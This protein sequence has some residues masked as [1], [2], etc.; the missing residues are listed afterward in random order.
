MSEEV[1]NEVVEG[2][3]KESIFQK[4]K[5][6]FI[7]HKK[8]R[9]ILLVVIVLLLCLLLLGI[10]K[11]FFHDKRKGEN[12]FSIVN[13]DKKSSGK[14]LQLEDVLV[15]KTKNGSLE[16][17]KKHLY[18]EPA[19]RYEIKE[20][21]K[22][23]YE[24]KIQ[25]VPSDKIINAKF[26]DQNVID[27]QWAFQSTK[28]FVVNSI[29]PVDGS[30]GISPNTTIEILFSYP[31]LTDIKDYVEISPAVEGEFVSNGRLWIFKPSAPLQTNTVYTVTVKDSLK[32]GEESLKEP[33]Q[34]SFSTFENSTK[35]TGTK[36]Y[37]SI[38]IDDI[39]TFRPSDPIAIRV[40]NNSQVN[41]KVARV[42]ILKVQS[43][44]DFQKLLEK[45]TDVQTTSLGNYSFQE[46]SKDLYILNDSLPVGYYLGNVY[47]E[48]G[49]ILFSFPIQVH[50]LSAYLVASQ[51][52]ILV[53]V[54]KGDSLLEGIPVQYLDKNVKTDK[55]G[56]AKIASYNTK[57]EKMQIVKIGDNQ[58]IFV[59]V[60]TNNNTQYPNAYIYTDRPL[61]KNTDEIQI[62]GYI[63]MAHFKEFS[64]TPKD[65]YLSVGDEA[66]PVEIKKDGTFMT[67][68]SLKNYKD[69]YLNI[70]LHYQNT[71]IGNRGVE[72]Y[73]YEKEMYDF[74]IDMD[75]NY[76]KANDKF[77]FTVRVDHISGVKVPN[78]EITATVGKKVYTAVTDE[79]GVASFDIDTEF[80]NS[81]ST[82]YHSEYVRVTSSL[83]EYAAKGIGFY[84]YV[85]DRYITLDNY[86]YQAKKQS[87]SGEIYYLSNQTDKG[88][89]KYINADL[90]DKMYQ[91]TVSVTLEENVSTRHLVGQ[92]YNAFTKQNEPYYNW[93]NE[94][95]NVYDTSVEVKN[96]QFQMDIPY[97]LK[98]STADL[99]YS[100]TLLITMK[101]LNDVT[102]QYTG[103]IYRNS[104]NVSN[105]GYYSYESYPVSSNYNYFSYYF[106]YERKKNSI[107]DKTYLNLFHYTGVAE[108]NDNPLLIVKY[109]NQIYNQKIYQNKQNL[110]ISFNEEDVPGYDFTSAYFKDG[111]FYRMPSSYQDYQENDSKLDIK[112]TPNKKK[113]TP[114]EKVTC[115][116]NV[117][118]GGKGIASKLNISVVDEGVFKVAEDMTNILDKIYL[119]KFYY[120]YTYSTYRDYSFYDLGGGGGSTSGANRAN[121]GDTIY[122]DTIETDKNGNAKV[123]FTLNDSIT[124]FRIT[125]HAANENTDVGAEHIN[126]N[127]SLPISVSTVIPRGL[128][129]DDDVVLNATGIGGTKENITYD[130]SIEGVD[131]KISKTGIIGSPVYVNFGKLAPGEYKAIIRATAGK[132]TDAMEFTFSVQNSQTEIF[133][134]NTGSISKVKSIKP[135][136]NPIQLEF[137]RTSF[138]DY[139]N[140]LDIIKDHN[141]ERIDTLFAYQ[142]AMEF[143]NEYAEGE[144]SVDIG[145]VSAFRGETG[146]KYLAGENVS[147]PL[148]AFLAYYD[149]SYQFDKT[150]Y[151]NIVQDSNKSKEEQLDAYLV[152]AAMKEPVL[153]DLDY[154][155]SKDGMSE[156]TAL[157]YLFLGDYQKVKKYHFVN[158][159]L[160]TYAATFF[161]KKEAA[162]EIK[163]LSENDISNRYLYF[164]II[165]YFKNNKVDLDSVSKVTVSYGKKKETIAISS[166]G[167][168]KLKIYQDDLDTLKFKSTADDIYV[169]YFYEGSIDEIDQNKKVEDLA[170]SL[171]S[172]SVSLGDTVILTVQF[173]NHD[174]PFWLYLPNGLRLSNEKTGV[175]VILNRIDHVKVSKPYN[176][177]EV[178]IPLYASSPGQ[179][180]IEPIV[181]LEDDHYLMS[182]SL[183][184]TVTE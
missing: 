155:V 165:S 138:K 73:H 96:G 183:S 167:K 136:K 6:F 81:L 91:G 107:S 5:I 181:A 8:L 182:N 144:N 47:E 13:V 85:I 168:K 124:S 97:A 28:N 129:K 3:V 42:E 27:D 83:S 41:K 45:K 164:S 75:N 157:A 44:N 101:D 38:T 147:Y 100:Y 26:V 126:I 48:N 94:K 162:E 102:Y 35:T 118:K 104:E 37:S 180:V 25:D 17:V 18:F 71:N 179:Y 88:N 110:A 178:Q 80:N 142:K 117:S 50:E 20:N 175:P 161:N 74:I 111:V 109:K 86:N 140:F 39:S 106:D 22:D 57:E 103:Y 10:K 172:D 151:Y 30:K 32:R 36:Y 34:S 135:T 19:V 2:L 76:V 114:G 141:E 66:V 79:N 148:T 54:G 173:H 170:L 7:N 149:D 84:F 52:D 70:T 89:I 87:V 15:V 51:S 125:V 46:V 11:F 112:I 156:K 184:I 1:N 174:K 152:L 116:I 143:E 40:N 176:K 60:N 49:D 68:Y 99:A 12:Y 131:K 65:F 16:E 58:P 115:E 146:W 93:T 150:I 55:D 121:F 59:G 23:E 145:D 134:K 133:V 62:W 159:G 33:F 119:N 122:F 163:F 9:Y 113:Y 77:H 130:F 53:W 43:A 171:S 105:N 64:V 158:G 92:R 139:A 177:D 160:S 169:D 24:V 95:T 72:V 63:P 31:D 4:I 21:K 61:Y 98:K 166:L 123:T 108:V 120:E 137:Y 82:N 128:K 78:K 154:I 90:K 14:Y 153:D 67:K 69:G 56:L 132:E 127:S 29:Y